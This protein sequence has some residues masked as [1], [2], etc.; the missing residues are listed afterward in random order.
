MILLRIVFQAKW[1]QAQ[2]VVNGIMESTE[3]VRRITGSTARVRVLTDL[4]GPFNTVVQEVE[5]ESLAEWEQLRT[6]MFA[7]PEFQQQQA[8]TAA[9]YE[10]G[11]LE[12]YTI[13]GEP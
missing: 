3:M 7:D 8:N 12:Y 5:L 10:S 4:S 13:E 6:V 11:R 9:F 1:G 2:E